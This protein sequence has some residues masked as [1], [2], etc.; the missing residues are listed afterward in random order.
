MKKIISSLRV[1]SHQSSPQ[2]I[3]QNEERFASFSSPKISK[4]VSQRECNRAKTEKC[5]AR[6][7]I[8]RKNNNKEIKYPQWCSRWIRWRESRRRGGERNP[9]MSTYSGYIGQGM[10]YIGPFICKHTLCY[11]NEKNNHTCN[12]SIFQNLR[13]IASVFFVSFTPSIRRAFNVVF[14]GQWSVTGH[15]QQ[16]DK[17]LFAPQM[18]EGEQSANHVQSHFARQLTR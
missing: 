17:A 3:A 7:S 15:V 5:S 18:H 4:Y 13:C 16:S 6:S 11:P 8:D 12:T 14:L 1:L 10:I 9:A 2:K